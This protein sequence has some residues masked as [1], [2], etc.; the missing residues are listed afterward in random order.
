MAYS[1]DLRERVIEYIGAGNTIKETCRIFKVNRQTIYKWRKLK[2]ETGSAERQPYQHGAIKLNDQKLIE[3]VKAHPDLY[4]KDYAV[5]FNMTPSGI[6]RAFQRLG[7]TL[8]KKKFV[9]RKK[10]RTK[11]DL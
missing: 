4:L 2:A 1:T 9:Q 3:F 6:C 8:K 10:G 7:I 11:R 5:P